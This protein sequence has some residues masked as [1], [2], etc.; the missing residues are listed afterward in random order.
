MKE[1]HRFAEFQ[2]SV[3]EEL[4]SLGLPKPSFKYLYDYDQFLITPTSKDDKKLLLQFF[5]FFLPES[6]IEIVKN[7]IPGSLTIILK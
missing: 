1:T 3:L 7:S 2:V 5:Q 6:G 4:S